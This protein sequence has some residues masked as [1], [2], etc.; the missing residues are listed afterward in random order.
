MSALRRRG[1]SSPQT[2]QGIELFTWAAGRGQSQ[3]AN[4]FLRSDPF[5]IEGIDVA[6]GAQLVQELPAPASTEVAQ[7]D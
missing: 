5:V 4:E 7:I 2:I 3:V 6:D 1:S